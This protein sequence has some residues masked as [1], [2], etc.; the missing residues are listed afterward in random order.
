[1]WFWRAWSR[2]EIDSYLVISFVDDQIMILLYLTKEIEEY[3]LIRLQIFPNDEVNLAR[4][5]FSQ[6]V[7]HLT[8]GFLKQMFIF[9]QLNLKLIQA[10]FLARERAVICK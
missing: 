10:R 4:L 3:S 8:I 2:F 5:T 1:M 9:S 6:S 7:K